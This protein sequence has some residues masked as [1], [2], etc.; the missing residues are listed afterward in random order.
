MAT[1]GVKISALPNPGSLTLGDLVP[2]VSGGTT[3]KDTWAQ[4]LVLFQANASGNWNINVLG[5]AGT[6]TTNANLTGP[7]TSIGNATTI[8]DGAITTAKVANSQITYAKVQNETASTLLGNPSGISAAPS[9]ITLGATVAFVGSAF[10]TVALTGDVTSAANSFVTTIANNAV[11]TAKIADGQ[12]TTA[13]IAD[14][15]VTYAKIQSEAATTLLGNPTGGPLAPSEITVGAT[16]AFVGT[17]LQTTAFSGDITTPVNSFVTTI[18]NNA[19]TTAKINNGAVTYAKIQNA[20]ASQLIGNPTGGATSVSEV[21]LGATLAFV[22]TALQTGAFSGDITTPVNSFV[23]SIA[24][25]A[26]TTAKINNAAVTYAK[27]QNVAAVQLIGNPTGG[28]LAPSEIS[29]GATLAFVSTALQTTAMSGDV[30][31]PAN[32]FVTTIAANAV[33]TAKIINSAVTYAKIQNLDAVSVLGNLGASAAVSAS[34]PFASFIPP[35]D[36]LIIAG[37]FG[38]NPWQRQT[39]FTNSTGYTADR[40][41]VSA[42]GSATYTVTRDLSVP[43]ASSAHLMGSRSLKFSF[44]NTVSPG[45]S[46]YLALQSPVEG[47]LFANLWAVPFSLSFWVRSGLTG[48]YCVQFANGTNTAYYIVEYTINVA[49]TWEYKTISVSAIPTTGLTFSLTTAVGI[50]VNFILSAGSS[51]N[52][53]T[54]N[55]WTSGNQLSTSNQ[56]TS[57]TNTNTFFIEFV[58]LERGSIVTPFINESR[59]K[60]L[61]D[62]YRYYQKSYQNISYAGNAAGATGYVVAN[63]IAASLAGDMIAV[64]PLLGTTRTNGP[65]VTLYSP[66]TG[67]SGNYYNYTLAA[68]AAATTTSSNEKSFSVFTTGAI[69]A[70]AKIGFH[71]TVSDDL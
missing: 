16:L 10:Q 26:V 52:A 55:A 64:V 44:T 21:S 29:V 20:A 28:A 8:T 36:N 46:D 69:A 24:N 57:T 61:N 17:V 68:D 12:V 66:V 49:D 33:T 1:I 19:I 50:R 3:V 43:D 51:Y 13:K 6:V 34:I 14:A 32:S 48:T 31:T 30:T 15:Q 22:G 25:N 58:K 18:A 42:V 40:F 39:T 35:N 38:I 11:T 7:V 4:V 70:A 65:T 53:G 67:A 45:G 56:V 41:L 63:T 37:E 5:N 2:S 9:E 62:C 27:I 59:A 71:Y 54:A 47:Y 23:A 60:V